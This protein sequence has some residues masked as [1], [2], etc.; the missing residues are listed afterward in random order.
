[1]KPSALFE[2]RTVPWPDPPVP[3][4]SGSGTWSSVS[5]WVRLEWQLKV[6]QDWMS[7]PRYSPEHL[8]IVVVEL[9]RITR[10]HTSNIH[11]IDRGF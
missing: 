3:K 5:R 1:M 10:S 2:G 4:A 7:D 6:L 9:L 8:P 11:R